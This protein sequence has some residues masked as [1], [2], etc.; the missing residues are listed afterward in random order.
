[1]YACLG[2][3][4]SSYSKFISQHGEK[5]AKEV[6]ESCNS[7]FCNKDLIYKLCIRSSSEE[8]GYIY[9]ATSIEKFYSLEGKIGR[10]KEKLLFY[11]ASP[12]S[13]PLKISFLLLISA[14]LIMLFLPRVF[15]MVSKW[16]RG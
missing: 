10:A 4:G 8:C 14:P 7:I 11:V 2:E 1:F 12:Y 16:L 3:H 15:F 5:C 6:R 9:A 13:R